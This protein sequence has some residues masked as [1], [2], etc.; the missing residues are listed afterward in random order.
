MKQ[1]VG[2]LF[3]L[4]F[5]R[6]I[7]GISLPC[8]CWS[9]LLPSLA[10]FCPKNFHFHCLPGYWNYFYVKYSSFKKYFIYLFLE[11]GEGREKERERNMNV[12][13]PLACPLLGTW[14]ATQACALTGNWTND[15]L[16]L[17]PALNT[18]SHTSQGIILKSVCT[19]YGQWTHSSFPSIKLIKNNITCPG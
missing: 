10:L 17:R 16:V 13:L 8:F 19:I 15:P 3:L 11:R 18:V 6:D 14:P 9:V 5:V 7:G 12:W 1:F 4:N 2:G